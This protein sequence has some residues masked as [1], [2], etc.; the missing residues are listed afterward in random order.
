LLDLVEPLTRFAER[1]AVLV[2]I[3]GQNRQLLGGD[4]PGDRR[5]GVPG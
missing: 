3:R 1:K 4:N 2:K 5:A